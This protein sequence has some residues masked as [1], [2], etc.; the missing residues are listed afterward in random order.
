MS[1]M[2]SNKFIIFL[3]LF[4]TLL[5][6]GMEDPSVNDIYQNLNFKVENYTK[7]CYLALQIM[8]YFYSII[9]TVYSIFEYIYSGF[10]HESFH[11]IYPAE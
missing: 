8:V 4:L 9:P 11:Q 6:K 3:L 10:R 7:I 1:T 5:Q 2:R